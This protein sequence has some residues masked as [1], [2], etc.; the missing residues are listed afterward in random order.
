MTAP[1]RLGN[2]QTRPARPFCQGMHKPPH[3]VTL[4]DSVSDLLDVTARLRAWRLKSESEL[5]VTTVN[6]AARRSNAVARKADQHGNQFPRHSKEAS[7]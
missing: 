3:L 4:S 1:N 7:K 5:V 6:Q 2:L